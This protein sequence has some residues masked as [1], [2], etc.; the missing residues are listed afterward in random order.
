MRDVI[1]T[2]PESEK[3]IVAQALANKLGIP[4]YDPIYPNFTADRMWLTLTNVNPL[5]KLTAVNLEAVFGFRDTKRN[6][7]TNTPLSIMEQWRSIYLRNAWKNEDYSFTDYSRE[8]VV[9]ANNAT[10]KSNWKP[11]IDPDIMGWIDMTY[12]TSS[13]AKALWDNRKKDTDNFL[14]YCLNNN[15]NTTRTSADFNNRILRVLDRDIVSHVL[16]GNIIQIERPA[17]TWNNFNVLNLTLNQ[18]NT[19]VILKKSSP[20][21]TQPAMLKPATATPKMRYKRVLNVI[22]G[23]IVGSG[24]SIVINW[25]NPVFSDQLIGGYARLESTVGASPYQ[26]APPGVTPLLINTVTFNTSQQV[27]LTFPSPGP[28]AAFIAGDVKFIYEVEVPIFTDVILNPEDISNVLFTVNQNYTLL[29][30]VPAGM[31]SP[32]V[33]K[34]W[35]VPAWPVIITAPTNYGKLKQM[36]QFIAAGTSVTEF[37]IVIENNLHM[38][39]AAFNQM[40]LLMIKAEN[41]VNSMY[42]FARPTTEELYQLA[43]IFRNSAKT[44]LRD[45]WV[46]EEIKGSA[47]PPAM[48]MLNGQYFWSAITEPVEGPWDPSLQT[49]PTTVGAINSTHVAIID[50]ELVSVTDLIVNPEAKPYR[51]LY[52]A[53]KLILQGQFNTFKAFTQTV[54]FDPN[55]FTKM[56]NQINTGNPA[57]PFNILPYTSLSLLLDDLQSPDLFKQ[58]T[59]T[60]V[61]FNAFRLTRDQFLEI[62][63]I[64]SAYELNDPVK[65]PTTSQ[66]D[67]TISILVSAF[68]RKRLYPGAVPGWIAQE[69]TGTFPSGAPVFYYNVIKMRMATGR[70]DFVNRKL[71][72]NTLSAWNRQPFIQSDI[73]PPE[74]IK[75]FV[76][77]NWVY[78][79]WNLRRIALINA[80]NSIAVYINPSVPTAG[81][82]FTNF[83]GQIDLL[84][85]R[86]STFVP[87]GPLDYLHYFTD[88][89]LKEINKEDIRP[90]VLQLGMSLT[91]YRF[92]SKI[93]KVLENATPSGPSPLIDSEYPDVID[94]LIHVRNVNLPFAQVQEEY[95]QGILLDQDYFQIYKPVVSSF[96]ITELPTFNKWRSPY[97]VRKAW[98]DTLQTRIDKEKAVIEKWQDILAA[99]EDINMPYMRD[100][101]IRALTNNCELFEDAQERLAKTYFVET[102]DNCCVKHS[103]ASFAIETLQGLFFALENGVYDDFISDF[104]LIA[105]Y[106]TREWQWL[107]SY[108]TWR[109]A[110][111]VYLYPENLLYPT[112]KR[113]QSPAF[114]TLS[115]TLRNANRFSPEDACFEAKQ[116]QNYLRDVEEIEIVC[117]TSGRSYYEDITANECCSPGAILKWETYFFGQTKAG[118]PYCCIKQTEEWDGLGFWQPL[119]IEV[120]NITLLGCYILGTR[121]AG[122]APIELSLYL[123][124]SYLDS[125][126]LKMG[127]IKKPLFD[128]ESSWS[129][130]IE[131]ED[132]PTLDDIQPAFVTACQLSI[133]WEI[134]CFIFSYGKVVNHDQTITVDGHW[135]HNQMGKP[136]S[137]YVPPSTT[138]IPYPATNNVHLQYYYDRTGNHWHANQ[139]RVFNNVLK[140]VTAIFHP[141]SI[142]GGRAGISIIFPNAVNMGFLGKVETASWPLPLSVFQIKEIIGAFESRFDNDT[143][144]LHYRDTSNVYRVTKLTV[145]SD[146]LAYDP[147]TSPVPFPIVATAVTSNIPTNL[148]KIY[149]FFQERD[150]PRTYA[151]KDNS[152]RSFGAKILDA[153]TT[154]NYCILHPEKITDIV[155]QSA[156]CIND[157]GIRKADVELKLKKNMNQPQGTSTGWI[158]R[159]SVVR[160]LLYE[161][162][163]FVPMLLALD[164]QKRGQYV[165]ALNWYRT[166]YDYTNSII[167]QRK[168]FYGLKLEETIVN[169][170]TQAPDWLLDPLN[171]H[172][173]AQTRAGAY[174]KY[175]LMNIIQCIDGFADREFTMDTI[176]TVPIARKLYTEALDL[177]KVKELNYKADMCV[178]TSNAC[179]DAAVGLETAK[180]WG[181]LYSK[182]KDDLSGLGSEAVIS[183]ITGDIAD[184]LNSATN[185]TYPEKFAAAFALIETST[186]PPGIIESITGV[187]DG[188]DKRLNDASR[189]LFALNDPKDF[190]AS[191]SDMYTVAVAG[192][193]GLSF[194]DVSTP[195]ATAKISWLLQAPKDNATSLEFG[196]KNS[197]GQQLL[198]G[199]LAYNP[200]NPGHV[201]ITANLGYYNAPSVIGLQ[202]INMPVTFA[203]LITFG[204]NFCMPQNPVYKSLQ[205]KGNLELYKIFNCRNIAGIVRELD[206][207]AAATDSSTGIPIIGASGNLVLPGLNNFA[208]TQ[209]RFSV[210]LERAKQIAAQA[211]QM[212]S[213]F[214]ASLE[215]EDAENYAQLR[216]KQDLETS[217]AT[218]KL[219]DLRINQAKDERTSA[220]IQLD[221]VNFSQAHY[222]NLIAEG[223]NGFENGSLKFL[224]SAEIAQYIA[225]GLSIAASVPDFYLGKIGQGLSAL[226]SASS[227]VAAALSTQSSFLSQLA[228]F[229]RREQEWQFQSQLTGFDISLANQQI[230]LSD[231]NIRIVTQEREIATLNNDHAQQAVD[232]LKNKFT[233]AELYNWMGGVLERSYSYMLNLSTA[234]ARTAEGQ[235]YFE[236]QEQAGPFILDDYWETPSSGFTSGTSDTKIDRRGLTGS[237]RLL[238]DITR[239][240]QH[241]LDTN[242]RKLQMTK[243]ISLAQN[244]PSE[245]QNFKQTGV[246]NFELTNKLFDYD[247]PGHYLRLVNSVKTTVV[248]LLPVYDGIKAT[249]TA[250]PISYTV[251]GGTTFQKIPIRRVEVDSVALTSPNNASGVFEL[252]PIQNELLRPFEAMGLESRWEFKLPQFSN[253]F[254]YGGIADVILSV[255][256]TAFDSFQYKTQVLLDIDNALQFNRGFSFKNNFPDQWYELGEAQAGSST[257]AVTV[258]LKREFF[259]QGIQDLKLDGSNLSL[260]FIRATE[261]EDEIENFDFS[262]AGANPSL[263]KKTVNGVFSVGVNT[264]GNT[265][266]MNLTLVFDNNF[267]NRELFSKGNVTDI[268]LLVGC[269]ATLTKYPL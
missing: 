111:F 99:A 240:E 269:K 45:T 246:I 174:T 96:P 217:R 8:N 167:D 268:A 182:L 155:I 29:T 79:T 151:L 216:A 106:F 107:G 266:I 257:F 133:D 225:A 145:N 53:R 143:I 118:K 258:Q 69:I 127:H 130:P 23:S 186:P 104:K 162:F 203:P 169:V 156:D 121:G 136:G 226:A 71:W 102:K 30:P 48:L 158:K 192:I 64:K 123:F 39:L 100:S 9:A 241:A 12:L 193:S 235:L 86:V 113:K 148:I 95:A 171:P 88:I 243:I 202:P 262:L 46:K 144:I 210:L 43:S 11:I 183:S 194:E 35:T 147:I 65:L 47:T 89:I 166:V 228:S 56:L 57:T 62:A 81:A 201:A 116:F 19:D 83:K 125:G 63:P 161:S 236:R 41:Y 77:A 68:K 80:Y 36:Y 242:K 1:T 209:Y 139:L 146:M 14:S 221:K 10:F 227:S 213:L 103:R 76:P 199:D 131:M 126:K 38:T 6:V 259:P 109:S 200:M 179:L 91:E 132:L 27:T 34:V 206:V 61:L 16:D 124:Y 256:Y 134:P 215:K 160:E 195:D 72:Q 207:F 157:M 175:T 105:P 185:E 22:S 28:N 163:Y 58:K 172:L 260:L 265:P 26:T 67:K 73:I 122:W 37:T 74:N 150:A 4:L 54:V 135:E 94:I 51:D 18:T 222:N 184:L 204:D 164:Q 198:S 254:D 197:G 267:T 219:Q 177:L 252:Q 173:I 5:Q 191:V 239:L 212:E 112:L 15:T 17:G 101:L 40:M 244:F 98:L 152:N 141:L 78:T 188:Q 142:G 120:K 93:Y 32:L 84:I 180:T 224:A 25:P 211:Q 44:P 247:F 248:G 128:L 129:S 137:W 87:P 85:R 234:I 229:K 255:E 117:S 220:T 60:D 82:L 223:L 176:E 66:L 178:V 208:P 49:I 119:P 214:L 196:F 233:N 3:I 115:D 20:S 110:M 75:N 149:P 237:A 263:N 189:Y 165:P 70:T 231:D 97:N 154:A 168:I 114:F 205:L 31:T 42:T 261:F 7:L 230:K 187:I 249:L 245:F 181:N 55:A 24:T 251:I 250:E 140:P 21:V 108:A 59:A 138:V 218:I 52:D 253:R 33:Y 2:K 238:V 50:P 153:S 90:Y 264:P 159:P 232:F 170:F 190:N 13:Y 92:L